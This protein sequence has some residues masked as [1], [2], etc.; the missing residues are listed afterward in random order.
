[1]TLNRAFSVGRFKC[2]GVSPKIAPA[3]FLNEGYVVKIPKISTRKYCISC[4]KN[5]FDNGK[6]QMVEDENYLTIKTP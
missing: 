1:M 4:I 5:F 2:S 3:D 6:L